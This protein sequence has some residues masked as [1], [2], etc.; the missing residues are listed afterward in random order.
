MNLRKLIAEEIQKQLHELDG[1]SPAADIKTAQPVDM[2]INKIKKGPVM[3]S[4][5][6]ISNDTQKAQLIMKFAELVG[7]P[8]NKLPMI[9]QTIRNTAT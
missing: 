5:S 1:E 7:V 3:V 2:I 4:L 9:M 8:K 6:K